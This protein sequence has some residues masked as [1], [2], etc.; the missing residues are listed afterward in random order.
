VVIRAKRPYA[1]ARAGTIVGLFL[2]CACVPIRYPRTG[3]PIVLR[4]GET[5]VFGRIQMLSEDRRIEFLPFSTDP[6]DHFPPDPLLVLQLRWL[7]P[8][9]HAYDYK[10]YP[11]P[12]VQG[13]GSFYWIVPAGRHLLLGNPRPF[14][15][16]R[17]DDQETRELARF[18]APDGGVIYLG[19]LVLRVS[20]GAGD[21]ISGWRGR[22]WLYSIEESSV[23]DEHEQAFA[24]LRE[25][26][27]ALPA[28]P[29][30]ALMVP[31]SR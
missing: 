7:D 8:P 25:R 17:F 1:A 19:T 20:F 15:S 9:G 12:P 28:P 30:V 2:L 11:G 5:L 29:A 16:D 22:G 23:V 10:V 27:P 31:D 4:Q 13:D 18:S 26:Y 21:A 14:G 24:R 3:Q 6:R